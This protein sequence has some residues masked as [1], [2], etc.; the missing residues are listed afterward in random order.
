M[1]FSSGRNEI[2]ASIED[3]ATMLSCAVQEINL[4]YSEKL[5]EITCSIEKTKSDYSTEC[6]E[7]LASM[8][9]S[10]Y[11]V[12]E[13]YEEL[14][15]LTLNAFIPKVYSYAEKHIEGL[16]GRI[17]CTLKNASKQY[18]KEIED[19]CGV[20]DI[21]KGCYILCKFYNL[22]FEDIML[23]WPGFKDFHAHRRDIVHRYSG[24]HPYSNATYIH[25]N[26]D[27]AKEFLSELERQT[28]HKPSV[29]ELT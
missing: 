11:Q 27:A 7:I 8:L 1:A 17:P 3:D 4:F 24:C 16:L 5:S 14:L 18:G 15:C 20:S 25:A 10:D 21:E 19:T 2:Q 12:M 23:I 6:L 28:R 9:S 22:S 13:W 26:I 29:C